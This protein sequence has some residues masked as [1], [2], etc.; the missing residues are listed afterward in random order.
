M[1]AFKRIIPLMN[2][3]VVKR[4]EM[5][6]KSAGGIFLNTNKE[7]ESVIG[8]VIAVGKGQL[9]GSGKLQ[10]VMV[11]VGDNVLLPNYGGQVVEM[12]ED[13][14]QIFRDSDILGIIEI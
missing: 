3:V 13:K 5:P 2:R 10:P 7:T 9:D 8:E 4:M 12:G 11:N 6:E 1:F 14:L